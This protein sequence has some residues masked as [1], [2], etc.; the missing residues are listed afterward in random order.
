MELGLY[1]HI[2]FCK[3]KCNYC[4]F[5]SLGGSDTV[6][7]EYIAGVVREIEKYPPFIC[8]TVY[9][10]G[11]TPSLMSPVQVGKILSHLQIKSGAEITLEA[12]P[13]T[14]TQEKLDGY[15]SVGVNRLSMGVQSARAQSLETL[16]RIH[17]TQKVKDSFAMAK[18]AGFSNISGDIMLGLD[19]Y[20]YEELDETIELINSCGATHISAYML[21]IEE[22]TPFY[23]NTPKHLSCEEE[24]V[25][26]YL[27]TERK[28]RELG[29]EQYEISNFAKSGYMSQ[30][31]NIYWQLGDYLGI[32]P[33]AH[34][35]IDGQRFYYPRDMATFLE[36]GDTM[37]D[38]SVDVDD[39]IMLSLRLKEGMSL[40]VL[41]DR[42]GKQLT[43]RQLEK[44]GKLEQEGFLHIK[45]NCISLTPKGF[46]VEN[47][48]ACEIML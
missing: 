11:G 12:N 25:D 35:S 2:P 10:G 29:Y 6:R 31:N 13:D 47:T 3:K 30:H 8:R 28:L 44:L 5:Y 16:G 17:T 24:L 14:L 41:Q 45:N 33:S 4:D 9:F 36:K 42:W 37:R 19:S 48:I 15:F 7:E 46:L 43:I 38:G 22:G 21:K 32:G 40:D 26:F 27:Y 34:S 18:K 1:I 39:Y 20:S 23:K